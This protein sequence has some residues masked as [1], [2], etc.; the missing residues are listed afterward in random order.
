MQ[1]PTLIVLS[2]SLLI[3]PACASA[4]PPA[5]RDAPDRAP[6]IVRTNDPES[7]LRLGRVSPPAV[8]NGAPV[9][10]ESMHTPLVE[11]AGGVVLEEL[12]LDRLLEA[13][14]KRQGIDPGRLDTAR[15]LTILQRTLAGIDPGS[16]PQLLEELRRSRGLGPER[17]EALLRRTAL[18]RALV[19]P[20]VVLTPESLSLATEIRF[21]EKRRVRI[22]T[23]PSLI[24]AQTVL[25]RLERGEAFAEIAA[26]VS[27]DASAARGGLIEPLSPADPS[28]PAAFRQSVR[29][30]TPGQWSEPVALTGSYA[31]VK[32]EEIIP[33]QS[34]PDALNS[35]TIET[36]ARAEQERILMTELARRLLNSASLNILDPTLQNAW[37]RRGN[38]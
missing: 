34:V 1:R 36:D 19:A 21:G 28:Y 10:W 17:F 24:D 33:A 2:A 29:A 27:T 7:P 20:R 30:L 35:P 4:P 25:R 9:S 13:E 31:I 8:L 14:A 37:R 5:R 26:G 11:A 6:R 12:V 32:L 16:G 38:Q 18:M 15:E 3:L 23:V 22:I